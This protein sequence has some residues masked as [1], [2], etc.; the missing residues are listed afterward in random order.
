[1]DASLAQSENL[2]IAQARILDL[3]KENDQLRQENDEVSSAADIIRS[4]LEELNARITSLEKEKSEMRES[5]NNEIMILKGNLQYKESEVAKARLR[6][7]ELETR[8]RNDFK[9][10]K[11]QSRGDWLTNGY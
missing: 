7:D 2:K 9:K 5:L 8:L 10:I 3:E 11:I 6:I 4:R 1:M